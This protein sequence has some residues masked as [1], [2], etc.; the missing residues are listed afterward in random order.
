MGWNVL[1]LVDVA[2]FVA[3]ALATWGQLFYFKF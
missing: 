3:D 1:I 2:A